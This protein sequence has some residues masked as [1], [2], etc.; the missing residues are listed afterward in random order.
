MQKRKDAQPWFAICRCQPF[1]YDP[2]EADSEKAPPDEG[3][4]SV[5]AGGQAGSHNPSQPIVKREPGSLQNGGL[6]DGLHP[7]GSSAAL[8]GVTSRHMKASEALTGAA[9]GMGSPAAVCIRHENQAADGGMIE[10]LE[11]MYVSAGAENRGPADLNS[12]QRVQALPAEVTMGVRVTA[13]GLQPKAVEAAAGP[14]ADR[15]NDIKRQLPSMTTT[16]PSAR[17][18]QVMLII[19]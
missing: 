3:H 5:L 10:A 15:E 7:V 13:T 9:A 6:S 17:Q 14:R 18:N 2:L 1:T 8:N 19:I 11:G 16:A 4:G 12:K